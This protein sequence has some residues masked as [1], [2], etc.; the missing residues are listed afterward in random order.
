MRSKISTFLALH[1]GATLLAAPIAWA[2]PRA[3]EPP[4][5]PA[6][7]LAG[8]GL[9][10]QVYRLTDLRGTVVLVSF[11]A[12]WCPPCLREMPALQR[13]QASLDGRPFRV[14]AVNVGEDARRVRETLNRLGYDGAVLLDADREAF[15]AWGVEGLPSS[16]LVGPQGRIRRQ[17]RGEWDWDSDEARRL[18]EALL[19]PVPN[20]APARDRAA[21]AKEP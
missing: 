20:D 7:P 11:W 4:W 9:D 10:R 3:A 19:P 5:P 13:L 18:I 16:Y 6:P 17:I 14:L 2:D 12:S 15:A 1:L 8:P 21:S